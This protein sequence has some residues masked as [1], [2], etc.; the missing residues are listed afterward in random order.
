[1]TDEAKPE[2]KTREDFSGKHWV[3]VIADQL[4]E[5]KKQPYVITGGMTTSGPPHLGTV[6]EFLYPSIIRETLNGRGA[7]SSFY[8]MA[9]IL[10][11][12]DSIPFELER[13]RDVLEPELGKPLVYT[14]DPVG[15]HA[16]LGEHYLDQAVI[17]SRKLG[18]E[19][20]IRKINELYSEG[21]FDPYARLF[22]KD[23][24]KA[25]EIVA[26]TSMKKIEEM[27]K[28][29]P[30]MP[31][32]EKCGRIATTRVTW[33]DLEEYEY[34]CSAD[35]KYTRGC[36]FS[37]R[38]SISN[39]KY[40]LQW[41][42]HWPS[43]QAIFN[44]SIEGSGVDHMT[45]GGSATTAV[46]IHREM[47]GREPPVYFKYGFV[48]IHGKKYSKSKGI[49][50]SATDIL[51][52]IPEGVLKYILIENDAQRDKDIDPTGDKLI[53]VYEDVERISRMAEPKTRADMKKQLAFRLSIGKL[54]WKASFVDI[55]LNFQIYKDWKR[56]GEILNDTE[57]AVYLSRYI[58]EWI[59]MG[60]EPER[61]NFSVKPA[62]VGELKEIVNKFS[63]ALSENMS[64]LDVHN[65]VYEVAKNNGV[66]PDSL[67]SVL[68]RA[69]IGKEKGPRMGKLVVSIGIAKTKEMLAF[70]TG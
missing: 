31:I 21:K 61:Y 63:A 65:L 66:K 60:Y 55:L 16:S 6:C 43:W 54:P 17:L 7:E 8:F 52:L 1:M 35:V 48:L 70:A 69:L 37:G 9:D 26:R 12:F 49:G 11:A 2:R 64:E 58:E 29:S 38:S 57:G 15:C 18:L 39:H 25:K 46:E 62:K 23:E 30:I 20:D 22:L 10:D 5:E 40:K 24:A 19:I 47:L 4:A 53:A 59:R 67:F 44:S 41:R 13:Y 32:C 51:K 33:H 28:W 3:D 56:V 34:S 50:M 68:Y 42:L 45:K 27:A 36:G 14:K